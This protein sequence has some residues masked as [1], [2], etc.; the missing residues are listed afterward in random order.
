MQ[1]TARHVHNITRRWGVARMP[2]LL[3][4]IVHSTGQLPDCVSEDGRSAIKSLATHEARNEQA[5]FTKEKWKVGKSCHPT[6]NLCE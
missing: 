3:L 6:K 1:S 4:H 2:Y 5:S